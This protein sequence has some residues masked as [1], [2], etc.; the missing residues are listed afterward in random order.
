MFGPMTEAKVGSVS[1]AWADLERDTAEALGGVRIKRDLFQSEADV[2]LQDFP[3]WSIDCKRRKRWAFHTLLET[4]KRKYGGT[5]ILITRSH[6]GRTFATLP[7][8]ELARLLGEIRAA[9][10]APLPYRGDFV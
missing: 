7:I 2:W 9:R 5:A 8:E 6:G 3:Q 4:V 1:K 10:R